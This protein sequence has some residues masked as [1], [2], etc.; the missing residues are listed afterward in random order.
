MDDHPLSAQIRTGGIV[1]IGYR[2]TGKSTVGRIVANRLDRPF[3]DCDA[4]IE[5]RSGSTIDR[6]FAAEGESTFRD[7]E[8]RTLREL[9]EESPGAILATGGGSI[10]RECNRQLLSRFGTVIWLAAPAEILT[11][12]LRIDRNPRPA[13]TDAG[14]LDEVSN[15]LQAREPLYR[16]TSHW[17]V[18]ASNPEPELVA[19]EVVRRWLERAGEGRR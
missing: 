8:E 11:E 13:L 19:D 15:V 7:W 12:R 2:A 17:I 5:K 16:E 4:E 9:C 6:L 18:D 10:L 14:L 1:L 3:V